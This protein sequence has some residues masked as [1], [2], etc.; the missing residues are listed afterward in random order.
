MITNPIK[1]IFWYL[2]QE[3]A[4]IGVSLLAILVFIPI[5][6]YS[7]FAKDIATT[8]GIMNR[9]NTGLILYDR[10]GKEFFKFYEAK[11]TEHVPLS[12]VPNH[13]RQAVIVA[14]DK[15]FYSHP[16]FS[17]HSIIAAAVA[18]IREG[19]L[20]YGGSTITQQLVKN[21]LLNPK[22]DFLRK[23]EEFVLAQEIERRYTKDQ[24]LEMYLNSVYFGEGAFGIESASQTYFGKS[25]DSLDVSEAAL[26]AGLLT[27]PARLS[28]LSGDLKASM[29]RRE[30]VLYELFDEGYISKDAFIKEQGRTLSFAKVN[31]GFPYKAPHFALYVRD[32][33]IEEYGE[34]EIA[35]S[36]FKVYTTLDLT[37]QA[38]AQEVVRE[39]VQAL[40][41]SNVTNGAAVV[42]D[43]KS[44]EVLAMVGSTDWS[45]PR[46][47]KVNM[48]LAPRQ[49]GSSF[50]PIIYADAIDKRIITPATILLDK[51]TTFPT[52][53]TPKNYDNRFRGPVTV[54]RALANS[55]NVPAVAVM[56]KVGVREGLAAAERF[57]ISTL[58]EPSNYGLSLVL[59]S[60]EVPLLEMTTA[61]AVFANNGRLVP[62][63]VIQRIENKEGQTIFEHEASPRQVIDEDTAFLISSILA[64]PNARR[65]VFGNI[66]T[67]NR[68]AAVKTGTSE[69]YRDSLTIGYTPELVVGVW[70]GNNDNQP[71]GRIAGSTGAAP[72]WRSLM[73]SFSE[74]NTAR[75]FQPTD[76]VVTTAICNRQ[77]ASGSARTE[78]FIAGTEPYRTCRL[79]RPVVKKEAPEPEEE[80]ADAKDPTESDPEST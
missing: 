13:V 48:A 45:H 69:D 18:N 21:S 5:F 23:Y 52:N 4:L 42:L 40:S 72:I 28:P 6:T 55:L 30:Y 1:K 60:G 58:S 77:V 9:N 64:D 80:N 66:L 62:E 8:S 14:E 27:A 63:T 49:P 15:D 17:F 22:K 33:L 47:G 53:Y 38:Y 78:Y 7:Y 31:N 79:E 34:E 68:P 35:R 76:G 43:P 75:T 59:G 32:R 2:S 74:S 61:Y 3:F 16:G 19:D 41:D 29:Q 70:V 46:W 65:E 67:I 37:M 36:G 51:K 44:G 73:M 54:R 39:Q 26:L 71:M 25:V 57:G 10:N 50:K 56:Q 12:K 11:F 20:S 24:I